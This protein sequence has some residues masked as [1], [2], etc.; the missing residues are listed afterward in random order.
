MMSLALLA[1]AL[2]AP[3][4]GRDATFSGVG[5]DTRTLGAG[6]L[7]V[8]LMGPHFDGHNFVPEAIAKGAAG[9][10]LSRPLQTP[11]P[12]V[13]VPETRAAFGQLATFWRRQFQIPVIAVTGSNGKT[14]VKEMIGAIMGETGRGCVTRGNLNNDI[15]VPLTLLRLSATDRYAV[16]EMGMNHP[17]EIA[18]LSR[19]AAPTVAVITNAAEAHLAGVGSLERI[20]RAKSEIFDG[21]APDGIAV[22]NADDPFFDFWREL[23]APHRVVTFGLDHPA[24]VTARYRLE[25]VGCAIELKTPHGD[26]E[27]RVGLIGKHNVANALAA[28]A[29]ALETGVKL[30]DVASGLQKLRAISGRLEL[31]Q[32]VSGARVIDDTY[33]ANPGSLTAALQVLKEAKGERVAVLG[34]MAELGAA[35][36]GMHR[37]A[38]ELAREIRID[39]LYGVGELA[40][41]AVEGFGKGG[42]HFSGPEA[43]IDALI[44]CMHSGMTV[45]VKGSRV[46]QMERVVAGIVRRG[47]AVVPSPRA[48]EGSGRGGAAPKKASPS[49]RPSP[50]RGEGE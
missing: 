18:Y 24:D 34:D 47:R 50:A 22:L 25:S 21:L 38:G 43:L 23:A 42:K 46:M 44:D 30:N 33:N 7:F 45:L 19:M 1:E 10:L 12:Y 13:R 29:A 14:T 2:R 3:L 48:G 8:A 20:A 27:I 35:A 39:R 6:D 31:K 16:I 9:A 49:P 5:T 28:T 26:A 40:A 36:P 11:L 41:L 4:V 15:G 17:D 37:R 32:G